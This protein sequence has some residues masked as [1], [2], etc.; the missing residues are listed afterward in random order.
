MIQTDRRTTCKEAPRVVEFTGVGQCTDS[1][2]VV[3]NRFEFRACLE[4]LFRYSNRCR[5]RKIGVH[6][7]DDELIFLLLTDLNV[8]F[9]YI[10]RIRIIILN[11]G[12]NIRIS[13]NICVSLHRQESY[14]WFLI[15]IR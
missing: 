5:L 12:N 8:Y 13:E 2:T 4:F 15:P 9:W 6:S 1:D 10:H 11:S 14:I 7:F 3:S